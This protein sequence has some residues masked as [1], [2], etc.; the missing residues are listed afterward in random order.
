MRAMYCLQYNCRFFYYLM[1]YTVYNNSK[2]GNVQIRVIL[3]L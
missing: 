2:L 1:Y 3:L